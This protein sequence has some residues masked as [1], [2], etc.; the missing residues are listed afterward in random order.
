VRGERFIG[1][2]RARL[3]AAPGRRAAR[4]AL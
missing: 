1:L 3:P 2:P 4:G